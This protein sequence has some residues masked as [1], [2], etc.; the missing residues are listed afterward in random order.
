MLR[1][2]IQLH[3]TATH[4]R[5]DIA[6]TTRLALFLDFERTIEDGYTL[7]NNNCAHTHMHTH[8]YYVWMT[9]DETI[10]ITFEAYDFYG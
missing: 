1:F 3:E 4:S 7:Q 5:D 9:A 10:A 8:T 2:V 6:R